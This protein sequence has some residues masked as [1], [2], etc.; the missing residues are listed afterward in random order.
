MAGVLATFIALLVL[1]VYFTLTFHKE[2]DIN[3]IDTSKLGLSTE[4]ITIYK[5]KYTDFSNKL[6]GFV[7]NYKKSKKDADKPDQDYFI[8]KAR[9]AE[10]LGQHEEAIWTLNQLLGY[11]GNSSVAWNNLASI[12]EGTGDYKKAIKYYQKIIDT[13][14][15][16]ASGKYYVQIARLYLKLNDKEKAKA[17]YIEYRKWDTVMDPELDELIKN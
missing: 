2:I 10:Y 14:G 7:E 1:V 16:Q 4:Q 3:S 8:E 5:T 17:N 13:F 6:N 12:H 9:Y 11:Y 15:P